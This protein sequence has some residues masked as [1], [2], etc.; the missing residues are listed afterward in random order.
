MLN[1]WK[2]DIYR[3]SRFKLFYIALATSGTIAF[4]LMLII[5][6]DIRLG[7]SIIGNLTLFKDMEDIFL[8]GLN[9]QKGLGVIISILISIFIGQEYQWKT[10]KHKLI[11][12]NTR[13]QIYLSKSALSFLLSICIF[14]VYEMIV[15]LFAL[16]HGQLNVFLSLEYLEMLGC[17]ILLYGTLGM[18]ICLF[19]MIIKNNTVSIIVSLCYVLLGETIISAI[20]VVCNF[21][22]VA[23][24]ISTW[25]IQHSLSGITAMVYEYQSSTNIMTHI[26]LNTAGLI[27]L[28][29]VVGLSLFRK[30]DL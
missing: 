19:S 10:W 12:G 6:M 27:T 22:D 8:V 5:S 14:L 11:A 26:F 28:I 1:V 20:K 2:S 16:I 30:Y 13:I 29:M 25:L 23:T 18:I 4:M 21:S 15:G 24:D 17:G 9:Y 7:I 3:I